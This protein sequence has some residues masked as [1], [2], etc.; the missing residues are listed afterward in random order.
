M[1]TL[2]EQVNIYEQE[3]DQIREQ[4]R[5]KVGYNYYSYMSSYNVAVMRVCSYNALYTATMQNIKECNN[6]CSVVRCLDETSKF[7]TST[8]TS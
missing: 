5:I 1:S 6:C 4:H 7:T 3:I 2:R 8:V